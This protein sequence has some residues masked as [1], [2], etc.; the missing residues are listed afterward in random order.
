MTRRLITLLL[1]SLILLTPWTLTDAASSTPAPLARG[2]RVPVG[3]YAL[4]IQVAS[5][6]SASSIE[7]GW[8]RVIPVQQ[9]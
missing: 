1:V 8:G 7:P 6:G 9:R 3:R 4:W 2:R 5:P